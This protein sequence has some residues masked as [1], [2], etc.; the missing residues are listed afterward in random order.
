MWTASHSQLHLE[1][2]TPYILHPF[3]HQL[4]HADWG[5]GWFLSNHEEL[6][7]FSLR[8]TCRNRDKSRLLL[9][10]K[11]NSSWG[12]VHWLLMPS[13]AEQDTHNAATVTT[14]EILN[15]NIWRYYI[16][17]MLYNSQNSFL[18]ITLLFTVRST[19][20]MVYTITIFDIRICYNSER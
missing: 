6:F 12:T 18:F 4:L 7:L 16:S 1:A 17:V 8:Q 19:T 9:T 20:C 13:G 15:Q 3:V 2:R 14:T 5:E 11:T 10:A